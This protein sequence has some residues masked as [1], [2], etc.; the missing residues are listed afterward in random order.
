MKNKE[1]VFEVL[2]EPEMFISLLYPTMLLRVIND[3]SSSA[4]HDKVVKYKLLELN[5]MP[6]IPQR[7]MAVKEGE[8]IKF[9]LEE[10]IFFYTASVILLNCYKSKILKD[11]IDA[12]ENNVWNKLINMILV[13]W[14]DTEK[15]INQVLSE[16]IIFYKD[17]PAFKARMD[18]LNNKIYNVN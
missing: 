1:K 14:D 7:M 10:S 8:K 17:S 11:L 16:M 3:H 6:M 2:I 13:N 15:L 9:S 5:L 12:D 18:L 4:I